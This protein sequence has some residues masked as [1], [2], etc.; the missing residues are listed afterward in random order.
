MHMPHNQMVKKGSSMSGIYSKISAK[1]IS[2]KIFR[3]LYF[4]IITE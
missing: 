2:F 4:Q 3:P 1:I